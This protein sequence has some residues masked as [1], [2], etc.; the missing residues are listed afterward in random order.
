MAAFK[1][2]APRSE[3]TWIDGAGRPL[4]LLYLWVAALDQ[5]FRGFIGATNSASAPVV[6]PLVQATNDAAA[7]TAGVPVGGLYQNSGAVRVRL[8]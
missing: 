4:Q 6:G 3:Q 7:K 8:T 2:P 1:Q 5:T